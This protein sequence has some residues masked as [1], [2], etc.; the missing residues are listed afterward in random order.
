MKRRAF[1]RSALATAF[2]A[3]MPIDRVFTQAAKIVDDVPVLT[4]SGGETIVEKAAIK[5]LRD[6]MRGQVLLPGNVGYEDARKIWNEGK[7]AAPDNTTLLK[8]IDRFLDGGSDQQ[9]VWQHGSG[10]IVGAGPLLAA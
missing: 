1:C 5:A 7:E 8:T 6:S 3:S 4:R 9:A 2:T 10:R